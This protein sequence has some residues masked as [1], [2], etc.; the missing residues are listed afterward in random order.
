MTDARELRPLSRTEQ[1]L[2]TSI[3]AGGAFGGAETV[4]SQIPNTRV[5]S[6]TPTFLSLVVEDQEPC[7][8]CSD[9][10]IPV[11]A[12][13]ERFGSTASSDPVGEILVWIKDGL[14]AGLE[15]AWFSD[16]QPSSFPSPDQI[17]IYQ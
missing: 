7:T 10:P 5:L 2:L 6:E 11:R 9:G 12:L 17:H 1:E 3:I 13:V 8:E 16:D 4:R 15:F 14:L